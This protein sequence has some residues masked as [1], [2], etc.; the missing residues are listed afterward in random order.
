MENGS[1]KFDKDILQ[2]LSQKYHL[3]FNNKNGGIK[4]FKILSSTNN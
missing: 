4:V 2:S 3:F 1:E